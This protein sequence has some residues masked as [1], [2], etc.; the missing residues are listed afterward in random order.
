MNRLLQKYIVCA[1]VWLL[2]CISALAA[3]ADPKMSCEQFKAGLAQALH[4]NGDKVAMPANFQ[5]AYSSADDPHI[6]FQYT[7]ADGLSGNLNCVKRQFES[8]DISADLGESD[9]RENGLRLV[10]SLLLAQAALC[11]RGEMSDDA[12]RS[13]VQGIAKEAISRFGRDRDRGSKH[14]SGDWFQSF[15]NATQLDVSVNEGGAVIAL[16]YSSSP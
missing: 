11:A 13:A 4:R 6:R 12:C 7:G 5:V 15:D 16:T 8:F 10:Q 14:P 3:T 2:G 9:V 1:F